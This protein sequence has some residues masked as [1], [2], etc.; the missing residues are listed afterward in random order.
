MHFLRPDQFSLDVDVDINN[1]DQAM[2]KDLHEKLDNVML[3]RLKKDVVKE[4]PTK[5]EKI[6]RVEMSAMQQRMYKAILTRNYGVLSSS[7]TAQFSLLNIAIELKKA[8]NHPFLFQG[9]EV[10]SE[11]KD[12]QLKGI[13][14][15]SGKMVLLD[16][17]LA[18]LK[19]DGHRVLIFS[20]MVR[21]LD[22]LSD[23][24]AMRGYIHQR[25]DGTISSDVRRKSIEH[26]NA[27]GSP[28]FAFLLSTRAGGLGINLETADT[29]IIFDSDWNPQNDLQAMARA[30]RLNSK[31]HVSVFRFLTKDTVEEDVLERAK[32]KMVLEYAIIHQMDTSGTNFASTKSGDKKQNFSKEELGEI[33][34]F[35]AQNMFKADTEDGQQKKLDEM[36][37]DEILSHAEAHD[38]EM[39]PTGSAAG[40]AGFLQQFAQVQDFKANDVTWEDIIPLED[41]L[42]AEEEERQKAVLEAVSSTSRRKAA[43]VAEGAYN[44]GSKK[45]QDAGDDYN[46]DGHQSDSKSVDEAAPKKRGPRKT[47]EEKAVSLKDRDLRVLFRGIQRW[48]DIRYRYDFVTTE[49]KLKEKNRAILVTISDEL[50]KTCEEAVAEAAAAKKDEDLRQKAVLVSCR[51]ISTI[52]ADTV[53]TRHHGLRILAENLDRIK[54]NR[55]ELRRWTV[56][57]DSLKPTH[58]WASPWY[59]QD[60]AMLLVGIWRYG[61]GAWEQMEA[62]EELGLKNK[63]F[64]EEG[65]RKHIEAAKEAA[66]EGGE[67]GEKAKEKSKLIPNA[68]HLVRRGDYLLNALREQGEFKPRA[69]RR[70]DLNQILTT[71][72][73]FFDHSPSLSR[74]STP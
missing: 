49:G 21:M 40:G 46:S 73:C 12:D 42:K 26:F 32:R 22:I 71:V 34:K 52:N 63:V 61:F 43:V 15:N 62:D 11:K 38:T 47:A 51:G 45:P 9:T 60:D 3:R 24:M 28:D 6:L 68:I 35:G 8:S 33:L 36:D 13:V 58:G 72:F 74:R 27:E 57:L 50:I 70:E 17:L 53:L 44:S 66:K 54:D 55:S 18:R 56:P 59:A 16:K 14:M 25:L 39:D 67:E 65:K 41:R 10:I 4:M 37:L 31:F 19:A 5:S 69:I 20:Q 64:L 30:H 23:Y 2:I 29:V 1:V 48:G 7:S